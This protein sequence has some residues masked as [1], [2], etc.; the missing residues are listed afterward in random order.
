[1]ARFDLSDFEWPV[2]EPLLPTKVR[3]DPRVDGR[4]VLSGI[5]W[6]L[7]A[8]ALWAAHYP[9]EP[10]QTVAQ[11]RPLGAHIGGCIS[12]LRGRY[13]DDRELL[14][15]RP[16][17]CC[18]RQK[19]PPFAPASAT[20]CAISSSHGCMGLRQTHA[21]PQKHPAVQSVSLS[22]PQS[23]RTL[24]QEAQALPNGRYPL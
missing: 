7:R 3:G 22:L 15:P 8:G 5:F 20:R 17:A 2:I 1:M 21:E 24:L 14:D 18:Q 16:P 13:P 9:R 11:G 4:K 6:R 10:L 23:G 19:S 12:S